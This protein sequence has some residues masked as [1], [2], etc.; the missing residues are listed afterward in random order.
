LAEETAR[1]VSGGGI[2]WRQNETACPRLAPVTMFS[3]SSPAASPYSML[4]FLFAVAGCFQ[5]FFLLMPQNR[6]Y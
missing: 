4:L 1:Q 2:G 5:L 3:S 6:P